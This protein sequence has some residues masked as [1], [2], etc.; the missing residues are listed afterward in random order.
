MFG[1][2]VYWSYSYRRATS[3]FTDIGMGILFPTIG[4]GIACDIS[5]LVGARCPN[6]IHLIDDNWTPPE[7]E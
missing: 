7:V 5:D 1:V 6:L 3:T 4:D 2:S